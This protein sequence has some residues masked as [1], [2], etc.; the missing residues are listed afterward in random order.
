M[1]GRRPGPWAFDGGNGPSLES[2]PPPLGLRSPYE[3]TGF[4]GDSRHIGSSPALKALLSPN[5]IFS[6]M[7]TVLSLATQVLGHESFAIG[8]ADSFAGQ[9]HA[10]L[11]ELPRLARELVLADVYDR[12]A[13]LLLGF[14]S[15]F[16][17][18]SVFDRWGDS[19]IEDRLQNA[20]R[21]R[22]ALTHAVC[23]TIQY[24]SDRTHALMT[25]HKDHWLEYH[26][27]SNAMNSAGR[28]RAGTSFGH[29]L[30]ATF[31]RI[32]N[33]QGTTAKLHRLA[34][35][36]PQ[37]QQAL[38]MLQ[39]GIASAYHDAGE[40]TEE[41]PR[42]SDRSSGAVPVYTEEKIR[43][44]FIKANNRPL[45]GKKITVESGGSK[46]RFL[47]NGGGQ[48]EYEQGQFASDGLLI[49]EYEDGSH[50]A[51]WQSKM[52]DAPGLYTIPLT[53]WNNDDDA[54]ES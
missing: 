47:T 7:A 34:I 15:S 45:A 10:A 38:A 19:L 14:T 42:A 20:C 48:I 44:I 6:D 27:F 13:E 11:A 24:P 30:A 52:P 2:S 3:H 39:W 54:P 35:R 50:N 29:L 4:G 22:D 1:I 43:L 32:D 9:H 16:E 37:L 49:V 51:S 18:S 25:T 5:A 36:S 53:I 26:R 21:F 40:C 17:R 8:V 23:E 12:R 31:E 28:G 41:T 33:N 46:V